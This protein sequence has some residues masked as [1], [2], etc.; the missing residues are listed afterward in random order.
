M[1]RKTA[2]AI[3]SIVIVLVVGGLLAFYFYANRGQSGGAA[4]ISGGT[5]IFPS[6]SSG[7][8]GSAVPP[9]P[10]G[11]TAPAGIPGAPA[12][13]LKELSQRPSAG[14]VAFATSSISAILVNF[15]ERGTGNVYEVSPDTSV[16]TRL[17]NTTIP[18]IQEAL[19]AGDGNQLIVRYVKDGES[20]T[21]ESYYAK[22]AAPAA[23]Q[24]EGSLAGSFLTENISQ[25]I[26][27]PEQNELFYLV[28]DPGGSTGI[29]SQI[30]GT[31]KI[32][33]FASPLR[34]WLAQWPAAN[35]IALTTKPSAAVPGFMFLLNTQ[36]G[37]LT[38]AISNI[39]GLTTLVSPD[40][41]TTL[42]SQNDN[43]GGFALKVYS[44]KTGQSEDLAVTT[45]PEKCVWSRL[46]TAIVYCAVP[47]Y[48]PN[49]AYPDA[50]Y[51][52]TVSFSDDIWRIDTGTGAGK[53]LA[54]LSNLARQDI[55][56]VN[57]FMDTG[58]HYLF[59]TNKNNYHLWSLR[60]NNQ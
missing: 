33:V 13:V 20:D 31:K 22:L 49:A 3:V 10:S 40:A 48:I 32:Q 56:G 2:I 25:A 52:G 34:E 59:F 29:I 7:G 12:P 57:L 1:Q 15:V 30:D 35:T 11:G 17:S 42:Y 27:N 47:S 58:E 51:Q 14:A 24:S 6:G 50:W 46:N 18:K 41:Q 19:W 5:G 4:P 16:E 55:D 38:R 21:I 23:G 54:K 36:S 60:L 26:T 43:N 39:T 9:A 37:A 45:L 8:Q 28:T 44:F 53:L